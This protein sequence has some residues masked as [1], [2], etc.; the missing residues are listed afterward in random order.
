[1]L[2]GT[3]SQLYRLAPGLGLAAAAA[4]V[5][6]FVNHFAPGVPAVLVALVLGVVLANARLIPAAAAPGLVVA[7]GPV[8]KAGIILLGFELILQDI[9]DPLREPRDPP[10]SCTPDSP[11]PRP[12]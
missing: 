5:G 12:A 6:F 7:A 2:T 3:K 1:M 10:P 9:V 11:G 8:P 4:A